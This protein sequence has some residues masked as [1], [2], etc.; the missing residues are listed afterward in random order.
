MSSKG[1]GTALTRRNY[2]LASDTDKP[3]STGM[4]TPPQSTDQLQSTHLSDHAATI[5]TSVRP[6]QQLQSTH[7]S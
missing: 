5:Y 3:R 2:R 4:K 6:P 1:G 7:L